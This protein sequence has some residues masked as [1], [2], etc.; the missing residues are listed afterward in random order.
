MTL[1]LIA[2]SYER[3]NIR[4]LRSF[5]RLSVHGRTNSF[6]FF[7][8]N[9]KIKKIGF[10]RLPDCRS[11]LR[12]WDSSSRFSAALSIGGFSLTDRA[13]RSRR[14]V[15]V[16]G[17]TEKKFYDIEVATMHKLRA[18]FGCNMFRRFLLSSSSSSSPPPSSDAFIQIKGCYETMDRRFSEMAWSFEY[19]PRYRMLTFCNICEPLE[20][21]VDRIYRSKCGGK[22]HSPPLFFNVR[23]TE[24]GPIPTYTDISCSYF[25]SYYAFIYVYCSSSYRAI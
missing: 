24:D 21:H 9:A 2:I 18:S 5:T 4:E 11:P 20:N 13:D 19:V 15:R 1:C 6:S 16:S 8:F 12:Y 25:R 23:V 14:K 17:I 10:Y 7:F 3:K 22:L